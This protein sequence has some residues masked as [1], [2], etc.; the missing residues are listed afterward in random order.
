[1]N[2]EKEDVALEYE[3][4]EMDALNRAWEIMANVS[5]GDWT[6]QPQEWQ[7]AAARWR[8]EQFQPLLGYAEGKA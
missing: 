2:T 4:P 7:D 1:M 8:D 5:W 6:K 3:S